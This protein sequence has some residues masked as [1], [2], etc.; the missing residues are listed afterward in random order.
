[1]T[2]VTAASQRRGRPSRGVREAILTAVRDLIREEG[3][4]AVTT[5]AVAERAGAAEAS[6]HYH[7]GG[8]E[9]LLIEAIKNVLESLNART[10]GGSAPGRSQSGESLL[11]LVSGL[12]KV[13]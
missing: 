11:E 3:L 1:M 4:A 10:P 6:I 9:Q 8:K 2:P 12:E 13:C 5:G 7:F